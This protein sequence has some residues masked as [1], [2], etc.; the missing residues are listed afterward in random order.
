MYIL[1]HKYL[2]STYLCFYAVYTGISSDLPILECFSY[3][4]KNKHSTS[5]RLRVGWLGLR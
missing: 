4:E 1:C 2:K 5:L 3:Q